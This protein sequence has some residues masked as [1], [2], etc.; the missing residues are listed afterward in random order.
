[1]QLLLRRLPVLLFFERMAIS[2]SL[3]SF[4]TARTENMTAYVEL[5]VP[6]DKFPQLLVHI[7]RRFV[8]LEVAVLVQSECFVW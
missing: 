4:L 1:M 3:V 5:V 8:L 7:V 2:V 6:S